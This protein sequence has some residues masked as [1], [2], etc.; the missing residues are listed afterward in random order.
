[1]KKFLFLIMV[2]VMSANFH[3]QTKHA[4]TVEDMWNMKRIGS[5][6]ISPDGSKIIFD[7][8]VYNMDEN[9]GTTNLWTINTDGTDQKQIT[10]SKKSISGRGSIMSIS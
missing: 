2:F 8:T 9:K 4:L 10:E 6:S 5:F 3:F 1:M 7:A